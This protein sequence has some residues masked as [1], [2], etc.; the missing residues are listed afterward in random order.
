MAPFPYLLSYLMGERAAVAAVASV[1]AVTVGVAREVFTLFCQ[2]LWLAQLVGFPSCSAQ[3][4][5]G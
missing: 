5:L 4:G 3:D 1:T 2:S